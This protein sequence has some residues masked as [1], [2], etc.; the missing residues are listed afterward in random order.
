MSLFK[1]LRLGLFEDKP[2]SSNTVEERGTHPLALPQPVP[3]DDPS[4]DQRYEDQ[5][6]AADDAAEYGPSAVPDIRPEDVEGVT[7]AWLRSFAP[8][9]HYSAG[10]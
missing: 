5:T 7:Q 10:L 1:Q 4:W 2:E 9:D 3:D 6:Q 8:P